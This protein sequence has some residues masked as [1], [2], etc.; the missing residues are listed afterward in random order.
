MKITMNQYI[1][2][3]M[4]KRNAVMN[5]VAREAIRKDYLQR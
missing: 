4:G 3:P 5:A 1:L 2:N